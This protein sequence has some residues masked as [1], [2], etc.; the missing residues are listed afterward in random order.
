MASLAPK[1]KR[2]TVLAS[3][4]IRTTG[5]YV[6]TIKYV[7]GKMRGDGERIAWFPTLKEADALCDQM[8]AGHE[9]W[10]VTTTSFMSF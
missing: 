8:N 6:E 10:I 5:Y 7:D 4:P 2:K 3:E 9:K 1:K